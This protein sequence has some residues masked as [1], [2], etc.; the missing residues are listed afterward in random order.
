MRAH[1]RHIR[2]FSRYGEVFAALRAL[3]QAAKT[4]LDRARADAVVWSSL[5]R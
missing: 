5:L 3:D 2:P 4:F 1:W